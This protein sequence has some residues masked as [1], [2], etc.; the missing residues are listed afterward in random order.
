MPNTYGPA[1]R[2]YPHLMVEVEKRSAGR[3]L[4]ALAARRNRR[5]KAAQTPSIGLCCLTAS[6]V[7]RPLRKT[8]CSQ[9]RHATDLGATDFLQSG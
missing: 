9:K 6:G 1:D 5:R 8:T 7:V 3:Q 2:P 4:Q